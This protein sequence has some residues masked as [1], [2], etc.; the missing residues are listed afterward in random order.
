MKQTLFQTKHLIGL[1]VLLFLV[2]AVPTV[3]FA[4]NFQG[5]LY[6]AF[7]VSTTPGYVVAS[8]TVN[9][10]DVSGALFPVETLHATSHII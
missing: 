2:I 7:T 10:Y 3:I 6:P 4:A 1:V 5:Q 8:T 9:G